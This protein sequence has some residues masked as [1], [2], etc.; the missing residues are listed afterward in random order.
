MSDPSTDLDDLRKAVASASEHTQRQLMSIDGSLLL[1]SLFSVL[2]SLGVS[3]VLKIAMLW[4]PVSLLIIPLWS[5]Y[6]LIIVLKRFAKKPI[7]EAL[8]EQRKLGDKITSYTS[9]WVYDNIGPMIKALSMIYIG[10]FF[11]FV[12]IEAKIIQVNYEIPKLVPIITVV[13]FGSIPLYYDDLTKYIEQNMS[14][15]LDLDMSKL[16]A[17]KFFI[18]CFVI[19]IV[20]ALTPGILF[21]LPIWSLVL[22]RSIYYPFT[23]E[24]WLAFLVAFLQLTTVAMFCS[25]F[26][27]LSARKELVNT[28]TNMADI[29]YQISMLKLSKDVK[30]ESVMELT[31]SFMSAKKYE[32][33][34]NN[35]LLFFP[36]YELAISK[37]H[38]KQL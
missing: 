34:V 33:T 36:F 30:A 37:A 7:S 1:K 29:D 19:I 4:I 27:S 31:K 8:E 38:V 5:A 23:A 35:M 10:T 24:I 20:L 28:L 26:S 3:Y 25:Y 11:V 12:G 9:S 16:S 13:L 22:I 17:S 18:G 15:G 2:I 21:G 14:H 32:L 6:G